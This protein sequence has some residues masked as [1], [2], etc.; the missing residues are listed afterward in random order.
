MLR[1]RVEKMACVYEISTAK[2]QTITNETAEFHA[3]L[4]SAL[5]VFF[6]CFFFC[7]SIELHSIM[8]CTKVHS[9]TH[10]PQVKTWLELNLSA[11]IKRIFFHRMN[12][13][14]EK[15][16][17]FVGIFY[18]KEIEMFNISVSLRLN[19]FCS[20]FFFLLIPFW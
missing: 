14:R 7:R 16:Y 1:R 15:C 8:Q 17:T 6:S 3:F 11:N 4:S 19:K 12:F 5:S 13:I 9:H 2:K 18:S 20:F 10:S